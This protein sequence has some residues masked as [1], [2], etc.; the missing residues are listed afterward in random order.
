MT[1]IIK[2]ETILYLL[3]YEFIETYKYQVP[4]DY[5]ILVPVRSLKNVSTWRL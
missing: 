4:V 1:P 5:C 2:Y 3:Q